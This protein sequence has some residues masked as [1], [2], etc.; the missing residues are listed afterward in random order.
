[1]KI[2]KV[3]WV[4]RIDGKEYG[5]FFRVN[6]E[7]KN[8]SELNEFVS[9]IDQNIRESLQMIIFGKTDSAIKQ[10]EAQKKFGL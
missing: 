1:M 3:N 2:E 10:E 6:E 7:I 8:R 5:N 4:V 9:L